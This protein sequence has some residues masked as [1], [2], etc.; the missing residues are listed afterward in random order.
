MWLANGN[1]SGR[2]V[3]KE[4]AKFERE[5]TQNDGTQW[6]ISEMLYRDYMRLGGLR[7]G[8]EMFTYGGMQRNPE[9]WSQFGPKQSKKRYDG[10]ANKNYPVYSV[11]KMKEKNLSEFLK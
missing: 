7:M 10:S 8:K 6:V 1:I 3:L 4:I 9:K 5:K 11:F 2:Q